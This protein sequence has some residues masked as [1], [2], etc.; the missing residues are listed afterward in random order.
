MEQDRALSKQL[1]RLGVLAFFFSGICVISS[2]VV[3]SLLQEKHG[4]DYGITGTLLSL[5][6]IGNLAA[7]FAAGSLPKRIGAGK[8]VMLLCSG[9][10]L[11]Y[12]AMGMSGAIPVLAAAF[13]LVGIAKGCTLNNCTVLVGNNSMDKT[14]GLNK[15]HAGYACGALL[16]PILITA[17]LKISFRAPIILLAAVGAAVW[18]VLTWAVRPSRVKKEFPALKAAGKNAKEE[19]SAGEKPRKESSGGEKPRE[20]STGGGTSTEKNTAVQKQGGEPVSGNRSFLRQKRFWLLTSLLF[21]Q[22]A[23]ESSV[24][25]WL[26]T[27]Y[28]GNGLLS[29]T[30]STYTMTVMWSATLIARLLIAFVFPVK[31]RFRVL[32]VMGAGCTILYIALLCSTS[33]AGA[34]V[35]LFLFAFAMA[36]V[37]PTVVAGACNMLSAESMGVMLPIAGAGAILMPW[38][39]GIVAEQM[40]LQAGMF[41]N[42]IPCMGILI[43]SLLCYR[44]EK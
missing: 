39:I 42:V 30:L 2:G 5:M 19:S 32:A 9:Y 7:S 22:L 41:C 38:V 44:E 21:C 23:S 20:E 14:K 40:S 31:N 16:G 12:L 24:T 37:N 26:V 36:G 3:V 28:K 33:G 17:A 15:M 13:L 29:G 35:L 4:F 8:T 25:G 6:N 43:F 18:F 11:G 27:Y 1:N 34:I 10:T